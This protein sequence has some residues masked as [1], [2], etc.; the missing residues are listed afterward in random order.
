MSNN[1]FVHPSRSADNIC[2][3]LNK[4]RAYC[5]WANSQFQKKLSKYYIYLTLFVQ[6]RKK[7]SLNR[8]STFVVRKCLILYVWFGKE[9][10]HW[11]FSHGFGQFRLP[12]DWNLVSGSSKVVLSVFSLDL[13]LFL[14][15]NVATE[16]KC[17]TQSHET[18]MTSIYIYI[19][20]YTEWTLMHAKNS[21]PQF[22][23]SYNTKQRSLNI[24]TRMS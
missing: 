20:T 2:H 14:S 23:V 5:G 6:K 3:K 18:S 21:S 22:H 8:N 7:D 13:D 9:I 12:Y 24:A 10:K 4:G 11:F 19:C 15:L 1:N 16:K 17:G